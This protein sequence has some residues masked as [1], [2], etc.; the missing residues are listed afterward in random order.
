MKSASAAMYAVFDRKDY[1]PTFGGGHDFFISNNCNENE[2][3]Y[4]DLGFTYVVTSGIS[5]PE[6]YLAGSAKFKVEDIEVY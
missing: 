4:S 5:K 2:D 1:G 6:T 3:S